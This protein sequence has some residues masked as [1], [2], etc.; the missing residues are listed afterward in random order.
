MFLYYQEHKKKASVKI[1]VL[2]KKDITRFLLLQVSAAINWL[3]IIT[4][5]TIISAWLHHRTNCD[6]TTKQQYHVGS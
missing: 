3:D 6:K 4:V 2:D 5:M 1:Y